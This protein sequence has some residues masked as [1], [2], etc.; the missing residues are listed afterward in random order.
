[1]RPTFITLGA[2]GFSPWLPLNYLQNQFHVGLAYT[3]SSGASLSARVQHTLDEVGDFALNAISRVTTTASVT[4]PAHGLLAGDYVE[5]RNSGAANLD[6][7]YAI[8]AITSADVFTYTVAN[9]G[10]TSAL[11]EVATGRV[12]THPVLVGMIS[13]QDSNYN[14]PVRA[15][16]L[17]HDTYSSGVSRLAVLQSSN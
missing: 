5:I 7:R 15:I 6:G 13:R 9:S 2:A 10:I 8:A 14:W 17:L 12:F 16:R 3:L 11:A 4:R 1:M